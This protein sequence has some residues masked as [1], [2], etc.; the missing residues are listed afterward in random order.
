MKNYRKK[1]LIN[2]ALLFGMLL[3]CSEVLANEYV[4]DGF[5]GG[6]SVENLRIPR[7][8]ICTL[9]GT[10]IN[11]NVE[12]LKNATLKASNIYVDGNIQSIEEN[13]KKVHVYNKSY[14]DGNIQIKDSGSADI[15]DTWIVGDL[16]FESNYYALNVERN[17][18]GGNMQAFK[19][20]GGISIFSNTIE[21]NLQCKENA[22]PPTGGE[23]FVY[24]NMEDQCQNLFDPVPVPPVDTSEPIAIWD[25]HDLDEVRIDLNGNYRLM[26]NLDPSTAGYHQL[27]SETANDGM[28]WQPIGSSP[29]QFTGIFDGQGF[30]LEGLFINRPETDRVG[31]FGRSGGAIRNIGLKNTNVIGDRWVGALVG[32]NVG[33]IS[34]SQADG[35]I[36]G[37]MSVGGLSGTNES[38]G[39]VNNS[40]SSGN[41]YG[42]NHVGGLVGWNGNHSVVV[43]SCST[44]NVKGEEWRI[45]GL[46]GTTYRGTISNSC[47][48]GNVYGGSAVG[49]LAGSS[50]SS[51]LHNLYANGNVNGRSYVGGLVGRNIEGSTLS[52]SYSTG[53]VSGHYLAGGLVGL[54]SSSIVRNSFWDTTTSGIKISSGGTGKTTSEMIAIDTFTDTATKGLDLPWDIIHVVR[55]EKNTEYTWNIGE[56]YPF[57]SGKDRYTLTIFPTDDGSVTSPGEGTFSYEIGTIV[58]LSATPYSNFQFNEWTGDVNFIANATA[59]TTI[60]TVLENV[61]ITANF[62]EPSNDISNINTGVVVGSNG[63]LAGGGCSLNSQ[64]TTWTEWL[65]FLFLFSMFYLIRK[66]R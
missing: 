32:V 15:R 58:N 26:R 59:A 19:N 11:G 55:D 8:A 17:V 12:I 1:K 31:L 2:S 47:A 61:S 43:N 30:T 53:K 44:S 29:N 38:N 13:V 52:N 45:G 40:Y 54:N 39:F 4:C 66:L 7:N 65:F 5:L 35:D 16:Q 62:E 10:Q 36:K 48:A 3:M 9:D 25:W 27:A 37:N 34:D 42:V 22:P 56:T 63:G 14:V 18:I 41:V 64:C 23:N 6:I 57:L 51:I 49:A 60:I 21:G 20:K 28:G 24:G 46:V 33:T 50:S